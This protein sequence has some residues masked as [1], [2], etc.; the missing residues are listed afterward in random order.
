M[1]LDLANV[2][3]KFKINDAVAVPARIGG[4][5]CLEGPKLDATDERAEAVT[6]IN[7]C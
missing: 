1:D 4:T 2:F 3:L 7:V 6:V 5:V